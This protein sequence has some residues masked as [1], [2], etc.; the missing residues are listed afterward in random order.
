MLEA[1]G[2]DQVRHLPDGSSE[3]QSPLDKGW[4][5]TRART[6][7]SPEFPGT[8]V[9]WSERWFEVTFVRRLEDGSRV[10]VLRPWRAEH[11]I[12]NPSR[13]DPASEA[14]RQAEHARSE[15]R[16][17]NS[18]GIAL[19]GLVIGHLP[20]H[21]QREIEREYGFSAMTLSLTS[22]LLP[23]LF[24]VWVA[25]RLPVQGLPPPHATP[26]QMLVGVALFVESLA[27]F[28]LIMKMS[29]PWG[30]VIGLVGYEIWRMSTSKGAAFERRAAV[31]A[32]ERLRTHSDAVATAAIAE[33][34]E[35]ELRAPF[36]ALLSP[37]EQLQLRSTY[38]FDPR[39]HGLRSALVIGLFS[40][41]GTWTSFVKIAEGD[42]T[43]WTW[44]ALVVAVLITVEQTRRLMVIGG[45]R[46]AGSVLGG[47]VRPWCRNLLSKKPTALKEGTSQ[48]APVD[49]PAVWDREHPDDQTGR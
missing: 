27:R 22:L 29:S 12:R 7:T 43:L 33:R 37:T 19:A 49:L 14:G 38:G 35:Y 46:P 44:S 20:S 8:P 48:P 34:D 41:L 5:G 21:A 17:R 9:L 30:S 40:L 16:G 1:Y 15:Q 4:R 6:S 45:G 39:T 11:P 3:I 36:L 26:G 24:V 31:K 13:Y 2:G 10:Y 42:A 47:L 28:L 18:I 23:F 25:T 32:E